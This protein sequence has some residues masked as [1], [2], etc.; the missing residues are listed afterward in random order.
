MLSLILACSAFGQ[1]A[2][3][4]AAAAGYTRL[5]FDDEMNTNSVAP[6]P[7]ST[8]VYN[9]YTHNFGTPANSLPSADVTFQGGYMTI[10]T[11]TSGYGYGVATIGLSNTTRGAW[12]HGYFEV[13]MRSNPTGNTLASPN[14]QWPGFWSFDVNGTQGLWTNNVPYGE[15]DIIE[16]IPSGGAGTSVFPYTATQQWL[17]GVAGAG[18]TPF[19]PPVPGGFDYSI[20]HVWG[21]L[22]TTNQVQTYLDGTLVN[23]VATGPGTSF[24]G[25]ELS[26]IFLILGT[27]PN[28]PT[29]F[30]Y[31]RVYEPAGGSMA[32]GNGKD[33]GNGVTQ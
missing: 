23:T 21:C 32:G 33:G 29:D 25:I 8:G 15:I 16:Y 11:D 19:V 18:S 2:P 17:N 7:S 27:G 24:T 14:Q 26:N 4:Y 1:T 6:S 22:W 5:V 9:W 3:S 10:T 30:D 13:S 20:F 28:W 12:H 31:V